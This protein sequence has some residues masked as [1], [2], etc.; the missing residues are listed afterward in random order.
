METL[1]TVVVARKQKKKG[2]TKKSKKQK[3]QKTAVAVAV[4]REP[5]KKATKKSK[6]ALF[7]ILAKDDPE[8]QDE[9]DHIEAIS[10][11]SAKI[12]S[13]FYA[14]GFHEPAAPLEINLT[15]SGKRL[16]FPMS[17]AVFASTA[18]QELETASSPSPF[19]A[20]AKTVLD[21]S[22][23]QARQLLPSDF[24]VN[25]DPVSS[26][27]L[28]RVRQALVPDAAEITAELHK[29]NHY[30]VGGHFAEHQDTPRDPTMFGSLVVALPTPFQGGQLSVSHGDH[31]VTFKWGKQLSP[32]DKRHDETTEAWQKRREDFTPMREM[33]WAAFFGDCKHSVNRVNSGNRLTLT[34]NLRRSE[35]N[36]ET[37]FL[38]YRAIGLQ[39]TIGDALRDPTFMTYGGAIG[40][41]CRHLYEESAL[42]N[43]EKRLQAKAGAA[44]PVSARALK[45]K[46][47]DAVVA[48]AAASFGLQVIDACCP[49]V[50]C[51]T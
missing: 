31:M 12:E 21:P 39:N 4:A 42:S 40:F 41:C 8:I 26:G 20:G 44:K 15:S 24:T 7:Q 14:S 6:K 47:E 49:R 51:L 25:F 30:G 29:L 48:I 23:R 19:G 37:D 10:E 46:N 11:A 36:K 38:R 33:W 35:A 1:T 2:S 22:V 43:S 18:L 17:A 34:Y 5:K 28:E 3:T 27:I 9:E 50:S 16:Q 13:T 45:L 32:T